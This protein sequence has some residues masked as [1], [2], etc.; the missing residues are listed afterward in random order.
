[1]LRDLI[2][3]SYTHL[4]VYKRQAY[5]WGS[6]CFVAHGC[7]LHFAWPRELSVSLSEFYDEVSISYDWLKRKLTPGKFSFI[8]LYK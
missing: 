6:S 4:D 8:C 7:S 5:G 1:M 2:P 3:V